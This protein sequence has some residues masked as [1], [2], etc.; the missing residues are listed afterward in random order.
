MNIIV[1]VDKNWA[2]GCGNKLL[3]HIPSDMKFFR[4]M[5]TG[6]VV[7]LGRRTLETFPGGMPLR[8]RTNIVLSANPDYRVKG[9]TVCHSIEE[10]LEELKQYDSKEIFIAGGD[11]V[12]RQLL[13]YCDVAHV[14]KVDRAFEAD[15]WFPNLDQMPEWRITADSD[16]QTYFDLE[17]RFL[18]YE[19]KKTP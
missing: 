11:S 2:I 17:F 15:A 8:N 12:Y 9:A 1:N 14:T 4:A 18:K 7:V 5:T 3:V 6:K 16:E 19:K 10:L 13:P